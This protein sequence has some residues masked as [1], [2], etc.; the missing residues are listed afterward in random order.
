MV[1]TKHKTT[2]SVPKEIPKKPKSKKWLIIIVCVV[3]CVAAAILIDI[4]LENLYKNNDA[5]R[6][7]KENFIASCKA[8]GSSASDCEC[9]YN[10]LK[11]SYTFDQ[12]KEYDKNPESIATKLALDK[13]VGQCKNR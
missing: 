5:T 6:E 1:S 3:I 10:A 12:I 7:F 9:M 11:E 4:K 8:Q 13:I 2:N